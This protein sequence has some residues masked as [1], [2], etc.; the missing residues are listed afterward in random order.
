MLKTIKQCKDE[1]ARSKGSYANWDEY[2]NWIAKDGALPAVVA[3]LIES[4]TEEAVMLF[5]S[6]VPETG[7]HKAFITANVR[8]ILDQYNDESDN[9][10]SH[11]KMV[12]LFNQ[13]AENYYSQNPISAIEVLPV[14]EWLN[15]ND[16]INWS[17]VN[18]KTNKLLAD[19]IISLLLP[20][21]ESNKEARVKEFNIFRSTNGRG[22]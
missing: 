1:I 21:V 17:K 12:Q 14:I 11:S 6:Q 5:A 2:Y 9:G 13:I 20:N 8:D 7:K 10:I 16:I 19:E 18:V 4:A 22:Q 3:Q 15:S